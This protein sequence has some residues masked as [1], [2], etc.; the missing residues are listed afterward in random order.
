MDGF[1]KSD[2]YILEEPKSTRKAE[3]FLTITETAKYLGI[4]IPTVRKYIR[5][6]ELPVFKY[7][8]IVRVPQT[9]LE[10]FVNNRMN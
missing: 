10:T 7:H 5:E 2:T 9:G 8:R 3:N 6:K 4:S 1:I